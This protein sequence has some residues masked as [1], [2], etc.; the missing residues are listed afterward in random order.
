MLYWSNQSIALACDIAEPAVDELIPDVLAAQARLKRDRRILLLGTAGSGKSS[1]LAHLVASPAVAATPMG[2]EPYIRWRFS[3]EDGDVTRSRFLAQHDK[4]GL[5]FIDSCDLAN[6]ELRDSL[7]SGMLSEADVIILCADARQSDLDEESMSFLRTLE[8]DVLTRLMI[9]V[10]FTDTISSHEVLQFKARLRSSLDA[11]LG[12]ALPIHYAPQDEGG[13]SRDLFVCQVQELLHAPSGLRAELKALS[14]SSS[15][16]MHR[17]GLALHARSNLHRSDSGFLSSVDTEIDHFLQRQ[18]QGL[19][20]LEE[21]LLTLV[22]AQTPKMQ[23]YLHAEL[24]FFFTPER[25]SC[26]ESLSRRVEEHGF[27]LICGELLL[28][29][30]DADAHFALACE[31]HWKE[32]RPR[33]L[34]ALHCEI[35]D[36]SCEALDADLSK[37]RSELAHE[38]LTCVMR[39]KL[40]YQLSL[41]LNEQ[42]GWMCSVFIFICACITAASLLGCFSFPLLAGACLVIAAFIWLYASMA[43]LIVSRS[44]AQALATAMDSLQLRLKQSLKDPLHRL[45]VARVAAYR[46][47]YAE[48]RL[49][50]ARR[51]ETLAPLQE[52][53]GEIRRQLL[54]LEPYL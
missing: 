47:L 53:L 7:A 15:A 24:G 18:L 28:R 17:Q 10:S 34:Q 40:R 38:L 43:Q 51:V 5:E 25:L 6:E 14:L 12:H 49:E 19:D 4:L 52:R 1:L 42:H 33:V 11:A 26:L 9:A 20:S 3:C 41:V 50:L 23:D 44:A 37:L 21:A 54:S 39:E 13:T 2:S 30:K 45:I 48:P 8:P 31:G 32:V 16:L 27:D 46:R 29:Q 22:A 35:G 36:F